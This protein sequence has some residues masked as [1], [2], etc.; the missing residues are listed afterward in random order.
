MSPKSIQQLLTKH[1]FTPTKIRG[2][3]FLIDEE[4][5]NKIV[6]AGKITKLDTVIEIGPGFGFLT[7]KLAAKA[8]KV[9]ALEIDSRAAAILAEELTG[10][11][12]VE[13]ILGDTLDFN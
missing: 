8:K 5:L 9:Q 11:S 3:N 12:N 7:K 1:N 10:V 13:I 4:A 6:E 2:Q